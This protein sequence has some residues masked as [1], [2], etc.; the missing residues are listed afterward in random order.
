MVIQGRVR[1]IQPRRAQPTLELSFN[2]K[3]RSALPQGARAGI[4]LNLNG[5]RWHGTINSSGRNPPYLHTRLSQNSG[6][7]FTC[8]QVFL[9]LDLAEGAILDFECEPG[10]TLRLVRIV[11]TGK[12]RS[13]NEPGNRKAS[14][15]SSTTR[16]QNGP[17]TRGRSSSLVRTI[18]IKNRDVERLAGA[19]KRDFPATKS[20][21]DRAWFRAPALRVIDCV[22]SLNRRYDAFV[23][24]RL[25]RFERLYPKVAS[26]RSL[27]DL[28]DQFSTPADFVHD[29]LD[30]K[31]PDRAR[32]L[33]AIVDFVLDIIGDT[34]EESEISRLEQW[35]K[36]A[37]PQ[38]HVALG[39]SGFA[40]AG[41]QYLR[42]LFG[43]NTTKPDTHIRGYVTEAVGHSVSDLEALKLL[44]AA[45]ERQT[46]VLRDADTNI[47]EIR[48][49]GGKN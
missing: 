38:D 9:G 35:A 29:V 5:K 10:A 31:D 34:S 12:W 20:S 13:G 1:D 7:T 47:W 40:I 37:R 45:A 39:I 44:E 25:N 18:G 8:T 30:Y 11:N 27:R 21:N 49:R 4:S 22:L 33:N 17:A 14:S 32:V 42:M 24:P 15:R 23:V 3:D 26:V 28:I 43:A 46:I 36:S 19:L 16:N 2:A 6:I 41:F 48:V